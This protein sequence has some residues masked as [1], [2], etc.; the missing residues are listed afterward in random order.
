MKDPE[1]L[2]F[3]DS[4]SAL[5]FKTD[6]ALRKALKQHT[7]ESTIIIIAQRV[8]SIKNAQQILVLEEGRIVGRGT[9]QELLKNCKEYYEI[10]SSQLGEGELA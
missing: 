7:G 5:D 9:H 10:A 6:V 2:I 3:D 4:F 8:S 1:I